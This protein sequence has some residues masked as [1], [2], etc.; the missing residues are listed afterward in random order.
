MKKLIF[1][2]FILTSVSLQAQIDY[3]SELTGKIGSLYSCIKTDNGYL[4]YA[5]SID[6]TI[7]TGNTLLYMNNEGEIR[8]VIN[9]EADSFLTNNTVLL[10]N[11]ELNLMTGVQYQETNGI[12]KGKFFIKSIGEDLKTKNSLFIDSFASNKIWSIYFVS[13]SNLTG[14][15]NILPIAKQTTEDSLEILYNV[16]E[17]ATSGDRKSY[18]FKSTFSNPSRFS[19]REL[20][21][22]EFS[23]GSIFTDKYIYLFGIDFVKQFDNNGVHK[24][25]ISFNVGNLSGQNLGTGG[26]WLG[27]RLYTTS[28]TARNFS[29]GCIGES[30]LIAQRDEEF[31]IIRS[32]KLDSCNLRTTG[33]RTF[34]L[35]KSGH[36]YYTA[37]KQDLAFNSESILLFKF[38]SLLNQVWVKELKIDF[39]QGVTDMLLTEEDGILLNVSRFS[40]VELI[41]VN[42]NGLISFIKE[43]SNPS[44]PSFES[45]PNP[46]RDF[47]TF[48]TSENI[49]DI[50]TADII[51]INGKLLGTE[52]VTKDQVSLELFPKGV[53]FITLKNSNGKLKGITKV[54]KI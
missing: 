45:F 7:S 43:I 23:F 42:P 6:T 26:N 48:K 8:N 32:K 9:S 14:L 3:F 28:I 10:K 31:N 5:L 47:V 50:S 27:N 54:V 53:Y 1:C 33:S 15:M 11:R 44:I 22:K 36:I 29:T 24:K 17:F 37:V 20:D 41:K 4:Y 21:F 39:F 46:T 18:L 30:I 49:S 34:I 35:S 25:N 12:Y 2:L 13:R 19:L 52:Q 38:D 51:G 16:I 40:G